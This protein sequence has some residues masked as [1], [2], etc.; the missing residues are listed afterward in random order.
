MKVLFI[1]V[2]PDD[3]TLGCG[4]T[5]LK[6]KDSGDDIYW[7]IITHVYE[8]LGYTKEFIQ[9][10]EKQINEVAQAYQFTAV[11]NLGY[12]TTKLHSVDINDLINKISSIIQKI[13]PECIYMINRS[14]I[15]TDHQVAAKAIMSSTKSFRNPFIKRILMY[16]C[17][18]ETEIALPLPEN[19][20]IS[21]VFSDISEYLEKKLEIMNLFDSEIQSP[22][23]P[24]SLENIRALARYRGSTISV[25]YAESFMLLRD[26]F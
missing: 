24:R 25:N 14:D 1:S 11:Y 23:M 2:H 9:K 13:K 19:T 17:I 4:G 5:I 6:H 10:R 8:S 20:F 26:I 7:L 15:H 3:E 21:N 18:S 12:Q 22:P 16:E